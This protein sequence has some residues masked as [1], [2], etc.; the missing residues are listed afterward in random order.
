M[1]SRTQHLTMT[2]AMRRGIPG[3]RP[4]A[5]TRDAV[6]AD[7]S[8]VA[9]GTRL[10]VADPPRELVGWGGFKGPPVGGTVELGYAIAP[11]RE[12]RGLA[13]AATR[14]LLAEAYADPWVE[15]VIAHTLP[16]NG[17]ST[18]VLEKCG[19]A[20]DGTAEE[21]GEAMWRFTHHRP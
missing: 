8:V 10:F 9:W 12:N 19:F 1:D 4:L 11:A 15:T 16:G 14:A 13:T 6:A 3:L 5:F 7:P 20:H 2:E 18:R 17:P 21:D